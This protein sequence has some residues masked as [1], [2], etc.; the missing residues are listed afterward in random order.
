M[1]GHS[2]LIKNVIWN[3]LGHIGFVIAGFILPR[4]INDNIGQELLG[5]WDFAWSIASY[6][7]LIQMGIGT[8]VNRYV[9]K[10][11]AENDLEGLNAS[12]VS[13]FFIQILMGTVILVLST[14]F[15]FLI[16]TIWQEKLG[17]NVST[18][19]LSI[20]LLG[21]STAIKVSFGAYDGVITGVHRWDLYNIN[22]TSIHL[23]TIASM[24]IAL[25]LGGG[26]V[27]ISTIYA[28][29][30]IITVV[31]RVIIAHKVCPQLS[32]SYK[33]FDLHNALS[34]LRFG[35]KNF[36][37]SIAQMVLYQTNG[38][39][40]VSL[41]GP[42]Y[43][44]LFMRPLAL[45]QHLRVFVG[46]LGNTLTPV[47][48]EL[49]LKDDKR[50]VNDVVLSS[51]KYAISIAV[52]SILFLIMLGDN[53]LEVWMGK[54]FVNKELIM[55]LAIGH[56]F[57]ISHLTLVNVLIALN[58]HGKVAITNIIA[59]LFAVGISYYLMS[60]TELGILGAAIGISIPLILAD[61]VILPTIALRILKIPFREFVSKTWKVPIMINTFL[62]LLYVI[63]SGID[64]IYLAL[65]MAV[66]L[67][68]IYLAI[69]YW[70]W[71]LP[72]KIKQKVNKLLFNR[73]GVDQF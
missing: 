62:F 43:L 69:T 71:I 51:T 44:A 35:G 55:I 41:L 22:N 7:S 12:V 36:L 17:A 15:Y 27:Q 49:S 32:I 18:A 21:F 10:H 26:V 39:I 8:S 19:Q 72:I 1:S 3:W 45:I 16:P 23:L 25:Y 46:K 53:L 5:I 37:N 31:I 34:M 38:L 65:L 64:N 66:T 13:V 40:I 73:Y 60:N 24:V 56:L 57:T 67:S 50:F 29:G 2:L 54:G 52:P 61:A 20:I 42:Q 48:T 6:F 58:E 9:A 47:I 68:I 4:S 33:K 14:L 30:S 63:S 28:V 59:G 70:V 11:I